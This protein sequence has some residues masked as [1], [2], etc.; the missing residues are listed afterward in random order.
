MEDRCSYVRDLKLKC[1]QDIHTHKEVK[2]ET[3]GDLQK[4]N[5]RTLQR[6]RE[7]AKNCTLLKVAETAAKCQ[8]KEDQ[9]KK[10]MST[11]MNMF[12]ELTTKAEKMNSTKDPMKLGRVMAELGFP[13]PELLKPKKKDTNKQD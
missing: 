3:F 2:Y 5:Y 6:S 12:R 9:F 13:V 1:G 8:A 7:M 11:K 10:A 4:R